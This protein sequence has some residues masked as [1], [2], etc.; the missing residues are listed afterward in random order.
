MI[1]GL[2]VTDTVK[3]PKYYK[4]KFNQELF[5][6]ENMVLHLTLKIAELIKIELQGIYVW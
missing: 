3:V 2:I 1:T 4:R 5:Y 6:C